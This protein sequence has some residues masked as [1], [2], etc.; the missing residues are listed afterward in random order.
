MPILHR[1][2]VIKSTLFAD[3]NNDDVADATDE[4][5]MVEYDD[6]TLFKDDKVRMPNVNRRMPTVWDLF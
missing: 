2:T 6:K 1:L 3:I 5:M 4:L